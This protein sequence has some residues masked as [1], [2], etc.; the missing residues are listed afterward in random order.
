MPCY[1]DGEYIRD[2]IAAL[3]RQSYRDFELIIIDDASDA[4]ETI[5]AIADLK[6]ENTI[7][8]HTNRLGPAG[9]R[10]QGIEAA[11][12]NYILPMDADDTI[13][14]SYIEKAVQALEKTERVGIV[15]S[16]ADFF[17]ERSG[18]WALPPYSIEE[19]LMGNIIF[20]CAMF[21]RAD[22]IKVGGYRQSLG[23]GLEDYDLWLS[24][25]ENGAE[26]YQI[27]ETL[28]HYRIKPVSRSSRFD[29]NGEIAN[30][31]YDEIYAHHRA[32]YLNHIDS[33]LAFMRRRYLELNQRVVQYDKLVTSLN[34]RV[35]SLS[36]GETTVKSF[37]RRMRAGLVR[38]L[39]HSKNAPMVSIVI[40]VFN[41]SHYLAQAVESALNQT[42]KNIEVLVIDDG[43]TDGG[44]TQGVAKRY[45]PRIRYIK[46]NNG[47]VS[48]ALNEGIKQM[49]GEYFSWLSHDDV[50]HPKKIA[51]Q[52]RLIHKTGNPEQIVATGYLLFGNEGGVLG[53]LDVAHIY[54]KDRLQAPLF[55]VFHCA[56]NGCTLLIHRNHFQRAGLFD[57][58]KRTTQDY[59]LWFRMLRGQRLLY[60]DTLTLYS[61][62]HEKQ[63]SVALKQTH[64]QECDA[65][66]IGML[67]SLTADEK[68]VMAGSIQAFADDVYSHFL[69]RTSYYGVCEYIKTHW[70]PTQR[71]APVYAFPTKKSRP[72]LLAEADF[73]KWRKAN[74]D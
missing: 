55:P 19:M 69:Y 53:S 57:E 12:G 35:A 38:R 5:R 68:C 21:K 40:P 29:E 70:H 7:K 63:G 30:R 6:R 71:A 62:I 72:L 56:V 9:A 58:R 60:D 32:L 67:E 34:H 33:F 18:P 24:L 10:N 16:K 1:N 48:S 44:L 15:Y 49:K 45:E 46:K 65:L 59:D 2:A 28:F 11:S 31:V 23:A 27:P 74:H 20:A 47:G 73:R 50:Y 41:G 37:W 66:W 64:E 42:Y 54:P 3:D 8:L 14:P 26:V 39:R 25:I 4:A 13:E 17:G 22:Y 52:M 51:N 36:S 43:S 61:R